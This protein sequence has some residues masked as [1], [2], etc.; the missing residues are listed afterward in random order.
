MMSSGKARGRSFCAGQKEPEIASDEGRN[1]SEQWSRALELDPPYVMITSWNE[2]IAGR[3]HIGNDYVF[4]DQCDREYSRDVEMIKGGYLDNYYLQ[5]ISGIRRYKGTPEKPVASEPVTIDP[6]SGFAPWSDVIPA[7]TDHQGETIPRDFPGT[8][9]TYYK[10]ESGRND[11]VE[12]KVARDGENLYF[13]LKTAEPITP[14]RPDGLLLLLETDENFRSGWIGGDYL[15]GRHYDGEAVSLER[16]DGKKGKKDWKWKKAK[17]SS[18]PYRVL[19]NEIQITV[20]F[21]AIRLPGSPDSIGKVSFKWMDHL[22]ENPTIGD[23]YQMGDVAPE[24][25]FFYNV[26]PE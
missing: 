17:T 15:I 7:L 10:N 14:E 11:L 8:G 23:L 20:P 26:L 16:F 13:Y 9:G 5:M 22:P 4:V 6:E 2:W 12:M 24:S 21:K 19:G 1:F 18:V 3:W 25:R